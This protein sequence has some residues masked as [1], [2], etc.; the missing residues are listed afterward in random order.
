MN[1]DIYRD[2]QICI[3]VPLST[4][5]IKTKAILNIE[6]SYIQ[7]KNEKN[8]TYKQM[9]VQRPYYG[10]EVMFEKIKPT[11]IIQCSLAYMI[12]DLLLNN[13]ISTTPIYFE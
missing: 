11:F 4:N 7:G 9:F 12:D 5:S 10:E 2:F 1:T 8:L 3:S 13:N 6:Y